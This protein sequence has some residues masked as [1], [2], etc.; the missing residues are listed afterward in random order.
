ML[1]DGL[2]GQKIDNNQELIQLKPIFQKGK[3]DT[4]TFINVHARLTELSGR[5]QKGDFS[6]TLT[7]NNSNIY[8]HIFS[9]LITKVNKTET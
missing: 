4:H 5:S 3:K 2:S 8:F 7:G 1:S 6:A 9:V